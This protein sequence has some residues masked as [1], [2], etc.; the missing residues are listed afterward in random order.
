MGV[1]TEINNG[2]YRAGFSSNQKKYESA[3]AKYFAA[4]D[5]CEEILAKRR[6]L[7]GSAP[8][9]AD[10]RLFP[11]I[12]RHDPIY[13]NRMKLNKAMVAD[14]PNLWRWLCEFYALRGVATESPLKQ[15]KQSYFGRT[16]NGTVPVGP[17]GY[18]ELL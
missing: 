6:F 12:F 2:A 11:T 10:V 18:P 14:Y 17:E 16:S 3:Y 1:Y 7:C 8:T 5:R 9:E 4:L 15:M 13:F